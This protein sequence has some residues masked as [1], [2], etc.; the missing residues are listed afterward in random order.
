MDTPSF[1]WFERASAVALA[2]RI[3]KAV[4][5]GSFVRLEAHPYENERGVALKFRVIE[6][7]TD[8]SRTTGPDINES[9]PCPVFCPEN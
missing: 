6:S 4:A 7:G 3:L 9:F 1:W 2:F 8:A 5:N